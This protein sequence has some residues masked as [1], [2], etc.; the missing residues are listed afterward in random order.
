MAVAFTRS[1]VPGTEE[2]TLFYGNER[3][4]DTLSIKEDG[5]KSTEEPTRGL[6]AWET[7]SLVRRRVLQ[8]VIGTIGVAIIVVI[9]CAFTLKS[10]EHGY[11]YLGKARFKLDQD[12]KIEVKNTADKFVL[13]GEIGLGV[14]S[15]LTAKHTKASSSYKYSTG[16]GISLTLTQESEFSLV[17]NWTSSQKTSIVFSDCFSLKNAH[18]YGGSELLAQK[19]PLEKISVNFNE[20]VPHS[21][22]HLKN[23]SVA[24]SSVLERYWLSSRGV[25]ILVDATVPLHVSINASGNQ[26]LCLTSN[27]SGY[28]TPAV[29]KLIYRIL[30]GNNAKNLHLKVIR[31]YIGTPKE[32]LDVEIIKYPL[33]ITGENFSQTEVEKLGEGIKLFGYSCSHVLIEGEYSKPHEN[34][35]F[36]PAKF[37]QPKEMINKLVSYGCNVSLSV[38][39]E[40]KIGSKEFYPASRGGY[41]LQDCGGRVPGLIK[42]NNDL[43]ACVDMTHWKNKAWFK[44]QLEAFLQKFGFSSFAFHGGDVSHLPFCYQFHNQSMDPGQFSLEYAKFAAEF[45]GVNI[46]VGYRSQLLPIFVKM[47]NKDSTWDGLKSLIPTVLTFGI[48]GYPYVLPSV[49]GGSPGNP[50]K[51]L[52][53]R[54]LQASIFLPGIQFLKVPWEYDKDTIQITRAL[55]KLRS[56]L[57]PIILETFHNVTKTGAPVIRPMW[58]VAPTDPEAL[59]IDSQFMLGDHYLVAPVLEEGQKQKEVYLPAGQWQEMFAG[60]KQQNVKVIKIGKWIKYNVTLTDLL[61]FKCLTL[62]S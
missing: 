28:L 50:E 46:N 24:F 54:W 26:K 47:N 43:A 51:E 16:D 56:T 3:D 59:V 22:K 23:G 27:T 20:Y 49:I 52:Y 36:D 19:W 42:S 53:I 12:K 13:F 21:P 41:L 17:V 7:R 9:I 39:P 34:Y 31:D 8:V 4:A 15:S 6:F 35:N 58:W 1:H 33:W 5:I 62:Y 10:N 38:H 48:I 18:W 32:I 11:T 29:S 2:A 25:A 61:Y 40:I 14:H 60:N 37:P 55:L 44:T 57:N 45:K 30:S